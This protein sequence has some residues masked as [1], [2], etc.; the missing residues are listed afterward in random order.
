[1]SSYTLIAFGS[2]SAQRIELWQNDHAQLGSETFHKFHALL[3]ELASENWAQPGGL[4]WW[5]LHNQEEVVFRV[6]KCREILSSLITGDLG[7]KARLSNKIANLLAAFDELKQKLTFLVGDLEEN[8]FYSVDGSLETIC[9]DRSQAEKLKISE[10]LLETESGE[11]EAL[12]SFA[13]AL[14]AR[15]LVLFQDAEA[16][17][18]LTQSI[19]DLL[20]TANRYCISLGRLYSASSNSIEMYCL[21]QR[22]TADGM[23]L[24]AQTLRTEMTLKLLRFCKL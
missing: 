15:L 20:S 21:F 8:S 23:D 7:D 9:L 12:K 3:P 11:V 18:Y 10:I 5:I 13:D 24:L 4:F 2:S 22:V 19:V 17:G 6:E 14:Q 16:V 1:M